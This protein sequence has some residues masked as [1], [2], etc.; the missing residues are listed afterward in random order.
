MASADEEA[1]WAMRPVWQQLA[2]VVAFN[3]A[4]EK[5]LAEELTGMKFDVAGLNKALRLSIEFRQIWPHPV[6]TVWDLVSADRHG[7]LSQTIGN[8]NCNWERRHNG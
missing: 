3:E 7:V 2:P 1:A 4:F 6:P 5:F 8:I